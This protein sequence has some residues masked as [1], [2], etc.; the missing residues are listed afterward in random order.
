MGRIMVSFQVWSVEAEG[1][2]ARGTLAPEA[3]KKVTLEGL[4]DTGAT[5]LALPISV[6]REIGLRK[7]GQVEVKIAGNQ[8]VL[9]DLYQAA[10]VEIMGRQTTQDVIAEP[11]GAEP[12][13]GYLVLE[14]TDL[15]VDMTNHRLITNP[16][17]PDHQLELL[18]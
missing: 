14:A 10:K 18:L 11:D 15:H 5:R 13:I 9:R 16:E 1:Q 12:L 17:S 6:I 3:L 2:V 7:L 8:K 4:V